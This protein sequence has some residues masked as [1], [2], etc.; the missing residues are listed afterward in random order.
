MQAT[1]AQTSTDEIA[2][3]RKEEAND[4]DEN[5]DPSRGARTKA[6]AEGFV[7][8]EGAHIPLFVPHATEEPAAPTE[9]SDTSLEAD[10]GVGCESEQKP[11]S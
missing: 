5:P 1:K 8:S 10:T 3:I 2:E 7:T 9:S 6:W 4:T 11:P